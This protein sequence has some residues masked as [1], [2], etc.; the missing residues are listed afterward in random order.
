MAPH[1]ESPPIICGDCHTPI[2]P[3][4]PARSADG[5]ALCVPCFELRESAFGTLTSRR[6]ADGGIRHEPRHLIPLAVAAQITLVGT[7]GTTGAGEPVREV[8]RRGFRMGAPGQHPVG[9]RLRCIAT[10]PGREGLQAEF[11]VEVRWCRRERGDQFEIGVEVTP[12]DVKRYDALY[13]TLL[14]AIGESA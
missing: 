1:Q 9:Q 8:S 14:A 10:P 3:G 4:E 13:E 2:E 11:D 7:D 5:S 12:E 6:A